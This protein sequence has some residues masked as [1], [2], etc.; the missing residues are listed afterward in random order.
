MNTGINASMRQICARAASPRKNNPIPG[1]RSA[2]GLLVLPVVRLLIFDYLRGRNEGTEALNL[3]P[4]RSDGFVART[5]AKPAVGSVPGS[6]PQRILTKDQ[7]D[8]NY[9]YE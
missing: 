5:M 2:G 8:G 3:R 6:L 1:S 4:I 9:I 7:K